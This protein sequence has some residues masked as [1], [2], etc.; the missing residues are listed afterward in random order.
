MVFW[1]KF[2]PDQFEFEFNED[3]LSQHGITVDEAIEVIWNGFKVR[4]NKRYHGGYQI[5]GNTDGG[6]RLKLIVYEK[7]TRVIRIITGWDR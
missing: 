1:Q 7:Q 5:I 6:R 4:R 2:E 3:E